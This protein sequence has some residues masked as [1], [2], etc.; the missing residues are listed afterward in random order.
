MSGMQMPRGG[1]RRRIVKHGTVD[2]APG[3][4]KHMLVLSCGHKVYGDD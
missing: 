3:E 1:P 2:A 4:P